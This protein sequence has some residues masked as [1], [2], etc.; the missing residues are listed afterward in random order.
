LPDR[1]CFWRT[2][3]ANE[4]GDIAKYRICEG[5]VLD[6]HE[7]LEQQY[8]PVFEF[9]KVGQSKLERRCPAL[10]AKISRKDGEK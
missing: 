3:D 2:K 10:T 5:E 7:E 4:R 6:R 8:K 9:E 1:T